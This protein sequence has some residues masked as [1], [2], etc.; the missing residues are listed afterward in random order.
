[1]RAPVTLL[2]FLT[3][4]IAS[5][6]PKPVTPNDVT[7]YTGVRLC[8][9]AQVRDLTTPQERDTT[10]G[11]SFHVELLL[12]PTC[13]GAFE[14]QLAAFPASSCAHMAPASPCSVDDASLGGATKKPTTIIATPL[15]GGRYD[16]RF[17]S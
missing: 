3:T 13:E 4:A 14:G 16:L 11:Y 12:P 17:Y 10:P 7:R 6:S 9:G 5:C 2:A 1:M 15:G 8:D